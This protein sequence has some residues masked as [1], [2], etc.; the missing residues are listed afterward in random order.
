MSTT[1]DPPS[2]VRHVVKDSGDIAVRWHNEDGRRWLD[3]DELVE[4]AE[5]LK[6]FI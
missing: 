5:R 4:V 2:A 1:G 3:E 6:T